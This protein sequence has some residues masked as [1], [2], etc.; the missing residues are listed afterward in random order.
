MNALSVE[1]PGNRMNE[2]EIGEFIRTVRPVI[3]GGCDIS[4]E[5]MKRYI[6]KMNEIISHI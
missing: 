5:Q 2:E 1:L 4:V 6:D 3:Y